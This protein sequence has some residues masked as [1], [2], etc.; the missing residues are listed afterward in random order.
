MFSPSC[1]RTIVVTLVFVGVQAW[2]HPFDLE[3]PEAWAPGA[4]WA[5]ERAIEWSDRV[6]D[7]RWAAGDVEAWWAALTTALGLD[8]WSTAA[9]TEVAALLRA[10]DIAADEV[11]SDP[12]LVSRWLA[13]VQDLVWLA[14][15]GDDPDAAP[16]GALPA[17][18][19]LAPA[20]APPSL[21]AALDRLADAV[22]RG[23]P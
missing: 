2:A 4:T 15:Y 14:A 22:A 3:E 16:P 6:P 10:A 7:L 21:R 12:A 11:T 19:W 8:E 1:A 17:V 9:V 23:R 20:D 13:D 5:V 18:G